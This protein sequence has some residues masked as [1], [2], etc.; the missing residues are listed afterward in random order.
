MWSRGAE[1]ISAAFP[2]IVEAMDFDAVLDGE[3]LVMRDGA[4]APF[5][6]LQQRL[7]RLKQARSGPGGAAPQG[8][9]K[10]AEP[11]AKAAESTGETVK[12]EAAK[13]TAT[14]KPRRPAR[15]LTDARTQVPQPPAAVPDGANGA[16]PR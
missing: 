7:D 3:L 6:D 1:D 16:K 5:A 2:E 9:V 10:S 4:V 14:A 8:L 13:V 12:E 11:E 15:T